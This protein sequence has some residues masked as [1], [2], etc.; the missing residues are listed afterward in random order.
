MKV[1]IKREIRN[2]DGTYTYQAIG[3]YGSSL[4]IFG[5]PKL[6]VD[7][8]VEAKLSGANTIPDAQ[9][10]NAAIFLKVIE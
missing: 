6:E 5:C 2:D 1:K 8:L 3:G 10:Q 9:E 7:T 4:I